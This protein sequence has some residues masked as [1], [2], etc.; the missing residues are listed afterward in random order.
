MAAVVQDA[1]R[2]KLSVPE[3]VPGLRLSMAAVGKT[4]RRLWRRI[5]ARQSGERQTDL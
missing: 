5:A 4:P 3:L 1:E 2:L